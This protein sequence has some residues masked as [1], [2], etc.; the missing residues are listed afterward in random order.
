MDGRPA[1]VIAATPKPGARPEN[2]NEKE[3]LNYRMKWWLDRE[4]QVTSRSEMEVMS[5][6]SHMQKGSF[7]GVT[8]ARNDIG[9]WLLKEF[10]MRYSLRFLKLANARGEVTQ[11][12]SDYQRFQA[13]SRVIDAPQQ[14]ACL[15][16]EDVRR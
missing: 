11:T 3:N 5:E 15:P 7:I 6:T 10:H 12:Y 8:S 13:D 1:Y 14:D 9:V 16:P 4:D 2:A